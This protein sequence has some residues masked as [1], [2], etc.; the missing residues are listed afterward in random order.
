MAGHSHWA[1]IKHKKAVIDSKRGKAWSK[2]SKAIIVAA[3]LGGGDAGM[4]PRLR[5]AIADAKAVNMPNDTIARA[6]KKG[7]GELEGGNVDEVLYEGYGPNG[8]AILCDIVTDNRNRTAPEIRKLFEVNGGKLGATNCVAYLFERKGLF[9]FSVDGANEE[10]LMEIALE[11]GAEDIKHSGDKLELL[12]EPDVFATVS[13]AL[14]A[15]D[16]TAESK[17]IARIPSVTVE[18]D[19]EGARQVLK[20][21]ELLDDHDDVQSVSANFDIS[22]EVI[23]ILSDDST[24]AR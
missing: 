7:T 1:G 22:D 21:M 5:L 15:A 19:L 2:C 20:L 4:N 18:L 6:I 24:Q 9:V 23:A 11:A 8:V 16:I 14:E 17:E 13:D 10:R 3:K 12:C